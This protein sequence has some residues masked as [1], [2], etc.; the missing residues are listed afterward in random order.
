MMT[1]SY[2]IAEPALRSPVEEWQPH[3]KQSDSATE[4][5]YFTAVVHD[6]A[7]NPYFLVW[8]P[9]H[10]SGE[11]ASPASAGLPRDQRAIAALTAFTDYRDNFR[12]ADFP[13]A[14]VNEADTWDPKTKALRFAAGDYSSEWSYSGDT[15]N[16]MVASPQLSYD[17]RLTGA[18]RVMYAKDKL[19]IKGFIQEG[20]QR[21]EATIIRCRV[22]R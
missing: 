8:C 10:F 5:W 18:E 12:I 11:K 14:V 1:L 7:G 20:A 16:L 21:T 2:N 4:W 19:G 13:V 15:M 17:L 6:T 22:S 3:G 9:F